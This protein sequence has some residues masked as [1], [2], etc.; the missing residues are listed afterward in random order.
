M[1]GEESFLKSLLRLIDICYI[2]LMT[3]GLLIEYNII[4]TK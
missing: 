1:G 2:P 3:F 4:L